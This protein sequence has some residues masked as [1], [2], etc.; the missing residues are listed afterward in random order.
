MLLSS[1]EL[2]LTQKI[3]T[4]FL[5]ILIFQK[6]KKHTFTNLTMQYIWRNFQ[7]TQKNQKLDDLKL[8]WT[9]YFYFFSKCHR[10]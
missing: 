3:D 5:K 2:S 6:L 9:G 8:V 1:A 7:Q 4:K 10:E